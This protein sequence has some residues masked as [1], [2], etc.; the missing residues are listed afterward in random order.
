MQ[1]N[2]LLTSLAGYPAA[3]LLRKKERL[4][5]AGMPVYDFGVGDPIEPT[6]LFIREALASAIPEV[7]Q[8]PT[9]RGL[10]ELREAAA[11]Y[12]LRRFL[13]TLDPDTSI[14]T[15]FGS[16]EAIHN[17]TDLVLFPG[18]E[19][20]TVIGPSPGYPVMERSTLLAGGRYYS[21][22]LTA[23]NGYLLQLERVEHELLKRSA[24]VWLNYPHNPTGAECD[25]EYLKRQLEI[26]RE[27]GIL[28]CSDECYTDLGGEELSAPSILQLGT[29]GVLAFHSCSKRSG[30]TGY[31]TGFLAGDPE[32]IR[33]FLAMRENL[34]LA[35]PVFIEKAAAKAWGDDAHVAERRAAFYEKRSLFKAFFNK[36]GMEVAPSNA[37]I[38]LW[39]STPSKL[40]GTEYAARLLEKG[41]VVSPGEYFAPHCTSYFRLAL[42]PSL[43]DCQAAIDLWRSVA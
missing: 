41:I 40:T 27:Y 11:A 1:L 13:V 37:T 10:K 9:Y 32:Y 30:M 21:Y 31:R 8:Y 5:A 38:Y 26:C 34:G 28:L 35:V 4:R 2:P 25:L 15:T 42:V 14:I 3:E 22:P 23:D 36:M 19:K 24:I 6:R 12:L 18:G 17:V 16:K 43:G 33:P 20:D 29:E 39:V 7:S